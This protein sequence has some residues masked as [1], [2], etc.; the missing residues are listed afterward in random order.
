MRTSQV[1]YHKKHQKKKTKKHLKAKKQ[2][3][4]RG[5]ELI[6]LML[7]TIQHFF[8]DLFDRMQ[9]V[10]ECRKRSDYQLAELITAGIVMFLLKE[11][12]RN[13]FNNDKQEE[14]FKANYQELFHVRLPHMDTVDA[15]MRK[16]EEEE[17]INLKTS[18]IRSLLEKKT[19]H[20][21]R[22]LDHWFQVAVDGT[23][24]M[25]FSERHCPHC[26]T[27]TSKK[28]KTTYFHNV[29][30]AKLICSN[31]FSLSLAN[32]WI[33]NPDGDF[34]KQD[35]EMK[36]FVRL[37][38]QLKTLYPRLPIVIL[39]DGLYPN[40][41][42]FTVC[43]SNTWS[44]IVT[45][46]D[47]NLP[48]IWEEVFHLKQITFNNEATRLHIKQ[49][50]RV[51]EEY[52]W[53]NDID[54][55]DHPLHWIECIETVTSKK[56]AIQKT[57][58]FVHVTDIK[59]LESN[60]CFISH[61]GRLRSKIENEGFNTQKNLGYNLQHKYSRVSFLASKNYYQCLQIAHIINQL[62]ELS[63]ACKK[64]MVGKMT[65]KHLWK[66]MIGFLTYH[67]V[68]AIEIKMLSQLRT[69]FRYE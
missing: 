22:F 66:S 57:T 37:A 34:T 50:K 47:G 32:E 12:S 31:G 19:L 53:I 36:A 52:C 26:L 69:Q 40:I 7:K 54:Y 18:M 5:N 24:V 3:K 20:K 15:V 35:C 10:K 68:N 6:V 4:S 65:L 30:E 43:R 55:R 48:T 51:H 27:K 67:V 39:A 33:E 58:R 9:Q 62:L 64:L 16:L 49:G 8:P 2:N 17:L 21:Y 14:H 25:S 42:F 46:K 63:I 56:D 28:G 38:E 59:I 29:L 23:G 61:A 45:F 1:D 60:A 41:T 13:A 11:G 44:Y